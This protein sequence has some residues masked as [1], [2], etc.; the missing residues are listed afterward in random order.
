[1][2]LANGV[3]VED[4]ELDNI[5]MISKENMKEMEA[6]NKAAIASFAWSRRNIGISTEVELVIVVRKD[7]KKGKKIAHLDVLVS[8]DRMVLCVCVLLLVVNLYA[9][10]KINIM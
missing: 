3:E 2:L 7:Q 1:M 10:I 6:L 5:A 4:A 8:I 9:T